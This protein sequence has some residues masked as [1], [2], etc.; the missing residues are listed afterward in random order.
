MLIN[1]FLNITSDGK[2]V[3][4]KVRAWKENMFNYELGAHATIVQLEGL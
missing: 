1:D 4:T 2:S 3:G